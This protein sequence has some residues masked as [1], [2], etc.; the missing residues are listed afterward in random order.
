MS[1]V[2][3]TYLDYGPEYLHHGSLKAWQSE[4]QNTMDEHILFA[5]YKHVSWSSET[6][7]FWFSFQIANQEA[8]DKLCYYLTTKLC[9]SLCVD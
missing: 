2:L 7:V 4:M 3:Y 1:K 5:V 6:R 9:L 8:E